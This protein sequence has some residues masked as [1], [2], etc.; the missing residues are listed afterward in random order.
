[1]KIVPYDYQ[2]SAIRETRGHLVSG[3]QRVLVVAP[4]GAGKTTI[5]A[6]IV[7]GA[8]AKARRVLFIAHRKELIDQASARLDRYDIDHGIIKAGTHR[9]KPRALVQVASIQTLVRR[10]LPAVD[11]IIIDEAHRSKSKSYLQVLACYPQAVT[12]GLTAT[13]WRLDGSGLG[14]LFQEMVVVCQ[15]SYLIEREPAVLVQPRVFA[16]SAPDLKGVKVSKGDF[17]QGA[18]QKLMA[19]EASVEEIV[20]NW[21][22]HAGDRLTVVFATGVNHSLMIRDAF[23]AV[24]I[25][26]EHV[27]GNTH[28]RER[29]RI[30]SQLAAGQV[31]VVTNCE[32]LTEG[33]DCPQV[34]CAV[35]ARP[36]KSLSLYLQMVGRVLRAH[37]GKDDAIILDHAGNHVEHGFA[38]DDREWNLTGKTKME[39]APSVKTCS[40]CFACVPSNCAACPECGIS[41][42]GDLGGEGG[43]KTQVTRELVEV[44]PGSHVQLPRLAAYDRWLEAYRVQGRE[45][46]M[47]EKQA[48]YDALAVRCLEKGHKSGWIYHKYKQVLGK[49]PAPRLGTASP[50]A[51]AIAA[52][53]SRERTAALDL[54][55]LASG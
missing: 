13:P 38:T 33:W 45:A 7:Q 3:L 24:G 34:A 27:D 55:A 36:T 21:Q 37:P 15:P 30:L 48:L 41:F 8:T 28:P 29:E 6:E 23:R 40:A 39:R 26:A 16:P 31:Q 18:L 20:T 5:A 4:T 17:E 50:L 51:A 53:K 12:L 52:L 43:H 22:R 9:A 14:D 10:E 35:L 47:E 44:L 49:G 25:S 1:M 19:T 2:L 11:L 54:E 42:A 46:T 32:V